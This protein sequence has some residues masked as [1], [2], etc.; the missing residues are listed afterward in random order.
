MHGSKICRPLVALAAFVA[1]AV[2]TPAHAGD[3]QVSIPLQ[4]QILDPSGACAS[5]TPGGTTTAPTLTCVAATT[6]TPGVPVCSIKANNQNPL[7]IAAT[8]S[9]TLV[10]TCTNTDAST[11]WAWTGTGAQ[12]TTGPGPST[13]TQASISVS[14]TTTFTVQATNTAGP[15]NTASVKVTLSTGGGTGTGGAV[16]CSA[17]NPTQFTGYATINL[18]LGAGGSA[19][20]GPFGNKDIVVARFHTPTTLATDGSGYA[21][22][23]GEYQGSPVAKTVV[24]STTA[25]DFT[26]NAAKTNYQSGQLRPVFN[27]GGGLPLLPNTTYYVNMVNHS[28]GVSGGGTCGTGDCSVIMTLSA[29]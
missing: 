11:T 10:A 26:K 25:C 20:S 12:A 14:A 21:L 5:W 22:S 4:V 29:P 15:S 9:V 23:I 7:T 2:F 19:L 16:N 28:L 6:G 18:D 24:V 17:L 27:F 1:M 13:Q 8:T 3:T